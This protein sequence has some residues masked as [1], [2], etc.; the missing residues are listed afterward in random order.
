MSNRKSKL[1]FVLEAI[2]VTAALLF[3]NW[4]LWLI[5]LLQIFSGTCI[6]LLLD[7]RNLP[8]RPVWLLTGSVALIVIDRLLVLDVSGVLTALLFLLSQALL[9]GLLRLRLQSV[10]LG[11]VLF[12]SLGGSL[13]WLDNWQS[14]RSWLGPPGR[15]DTSWEFGRLNSRFL[16]SR[17]GY[18]ST[19]RWTQNPASPITMSFE[20]RGQSKDGGWLF[21]QPQ[22]RAELLPGMASASRLDF[23]PPGSYAY[24]DVEFYQSIK[25]RR[26]RV[27]LELR[28]DRILPE[29]GCRGIWLQSVDAPEDRACR[30]TALGPEWKLFKLEF[31][32]GSVSQNSTRLRV[33]LLGFVHPIEVRHFMLEEFVNG[34][35][36]SVGPVLPTPAT[37]RLFWSGAPSKAAAELPLA[38][39]REWRSYSVATKI[40]PIGAQT[41]TA[42][43]EVRPGTVLE[44]RRVN[45]SV[46]PDQV[47]LMPKAPMGRATL[48]FESPNLLGH[49]LLSAGLAVA[50]IW[51]RSL[52]AMLAV[53][54][55]L[56]GITLTGSRAALIAW[57][58]GL[59]GVCW[60]A[61][62][63]RERLV[64]LA[65]ALF[66]ASVFLSMYGSQAVMRFQ[67]SDGSI[68]RIEI[69]TAA[70]RAI[71]EHPLGLGTGQFQNYFLNVRPD[72]T[73][74]AISHAH[75]LWLEMGVRY[76]I[77]GLLAGL[78]LTLALLELAWR[79]GAWQG[80]VLL[81]P[82]L[83]MNFFD[84]T[85]F[86]PSVMAA[87]YLGLNSMR[88]G[89]Q[90]PD[91]PTAQG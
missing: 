2:A 85:L 80:L 68:P 79:F 4:G 86:F 35:W 75:N 84:Y 30:A 58:I 67:V 70:T 10:L 72:Q 36:R 22:S 69:W 5:L 81:I 55:S 56:W 17:V 20:A 44:V 39:E 26:F 23:I 48:W 6:P 3:P 33:L 59:I 1:L 34:I 50:C 13:A 12:L 8:K 89:N 42:L 49:S 66:C 41:L 62:R 74:Q 65:V 28:S 51:P 31:V 78:C 15:V 57:V 47:S 73:A 91:C 16:E 11:F 24:R 43:L 83:V 46:P 76:G 61:T 7:L 19:L 40:F 60:I 77:L 32:P 18:L 45:V 82:L 71:L 63:D 52:P 54:L 90:K 38:L 53:M 88:V 25:Q 37:M 64:L 21:S 9:I 87:L 14:A 29:D 27:T